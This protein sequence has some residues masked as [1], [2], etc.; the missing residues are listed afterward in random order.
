MFYWFILTCLVWSPLSV[1][2]HSSLSPLVWLFNTFS[3]NFRFYW[4]FYTPLSLHSHCSQEDVKSLTAHIV[5]NYWKALEDVD[6]VQTF[7][8]LKLRYEQQRERQ[9]NPKLDRW[10]NQGCTTTTTTITLSLKIGT[11]SNQCSFHL[12]WDT[13]RQSINMKIKIMSQLENSHNMLKWP[14]Y[15]FFFVFVFWGVRCLLSDY[16]FLKVHTVLF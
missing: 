10:E 2:L 16:H 9:D 7:K 4:V 13:H 3:I 12:L 1:S 14:M 11:D 5:E 6:Y 8:G 15:R